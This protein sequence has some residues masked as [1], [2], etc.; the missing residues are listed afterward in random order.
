MKRWM[1]I[2]VETELDW[3]VEESTIPFMGHR[4]ILRPQDANSAADIRLQYEHPQSEREAIEIIC[5]F[6]S[7][8]SWWQRRP[9]RGRLRFACTAPMRGGKGG[10][11]PALRKDY[12][13]PDG[14]QSPSDSKARLAVA[15]YREAI[16][17]H[18]TPY[19]FLG[20]FKIINVRYNGPDQIISWINNA[21]PLLTDKRVK[22][23]ISELA[24]SKANLGE[25][26]YGSGRCAVAHAFSGVVVDPDNPDDVLRLSADM[27]VARTLAEH[28][29][30]TEF[31]IPWELSKRTEGSTVD[32]R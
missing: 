4:L 2:T 9:A 13:L 29:I 25:Y 26:L 3:P 18:S 22:D 12:H 27:P 14:V 19:E 15:L 7:A 31:G 8:F 6:L 17:V 21:I 30:E 11:G 10:Y 24:A 28:L 16:S 5:R 23:R 20:Y 1:I 32:S